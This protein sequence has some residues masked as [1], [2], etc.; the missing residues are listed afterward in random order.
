MG[1][2]YDKCVTV[3]NNAMH[4]ISS[5]PTVQFYFTHGNT[6]GY[7]QKVSPDLIVQ[8]NTTSLP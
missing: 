3:H 7:K 2:P 4:T 1:T 5:L 6:V 8:T